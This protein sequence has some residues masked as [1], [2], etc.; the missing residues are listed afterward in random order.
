MWSSSYRHHSQSSTQSPLANS[1]MHVATTSALHVMLSSF[2]LSLTR[3][4]C[5]VFWDPHSLWLGTCW[6]TGCGNYSRRGLVHPSINV[7]VELM[8]GR[9]YLQ[10]KHSDSHVRCSLLP[11]F[12]LSHLFFHR[13]HVYSQFRCCLCSF[14]NS[15]VVFKGYNLNMCPGSRLL[16][17]LPWLKRERVDMSIH[18]LLYKEYAPCL[19]QWEPR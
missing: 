2:S 7:S 19:I 8:C 1:N 10:P 17:I 14:I 16:H 12:L 15:Y 6:S 3:T 18:N 4:R 13:L 5:A 11:P 9:A